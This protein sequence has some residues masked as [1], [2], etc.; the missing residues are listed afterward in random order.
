M[1]APSSL[2]PSCARVPA[3]S[4][5]GRR[6]RAWQAAAPIGSSTHPVVAGL[7]LG[8][9]PPAAIDVPLLRPGPRQEARH[10]PRQLH[11]KHHLHS[12]TLRLPGR[13]ERPESVEAGDP[14][15]ALRCA[16]R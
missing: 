12:E 16:W 13:R 4:G 15:S 10:P 2:V 6:G 14:R 11:G 9:L 3:V 7:L 5:Q 8:E 1:S